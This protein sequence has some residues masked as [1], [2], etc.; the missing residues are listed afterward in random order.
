MDGSAATVTPDLGDVASRVSSLEGSRLTMG[1]LVEQQSEWL[2]K[3]SELLSAQRALIEVLATEQ[4]ALRSRVRDLE[5]RLT[6]VEVSNDM[7]PSGVVPSL[8]VRPLTRV[9]IDEILQE[10]HDIL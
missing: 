5:D 4:D 9:E 1:R 3:Q 2:Q 6:L 7:V 10:S 8:M